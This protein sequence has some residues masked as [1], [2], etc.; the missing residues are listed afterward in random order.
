[1]SAGA[2]GA[3]LS[4]DAP[5]VSGAEAEL[6]GLLAS[7]SAETRE[8]CASAALQRVRVLLRDEQRWPRSVPPVVTPEPG[9]AECY[10]LSDSEGGP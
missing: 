2:A 3:Y 10:V 9:A 6:L 5:R 4:D 8:R 7:L 1:M